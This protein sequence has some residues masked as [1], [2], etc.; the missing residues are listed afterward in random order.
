M[1]VW[2]IIVL[3]I[4]LYL[5][6]FPLVRCFFKRLILMAKIKV[7]CQKKSYRL[8]KKPL[9][10]LGNK[11]FG[12][13]EFQ[14]ETATDI[15][16]IKLFGTPR[17]RRMLMLLPNGKFFIR[18]TIMMIAFTAQAAVFHIDGRMKHMP[19]YR[20]QMASAHTALQKQM[21]KVLLVHPVTMTIHRRLPHGAEL[22]VRDG[23][24]VSGMEVYCLSGFLRMLNEK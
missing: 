8:Y 18:R 20:F 24:L 3:C 10:F 16:A 11:Y 17:R 2:V 21:H 9:W 19:R 23:D 22:I 7:I 15:F 12:Y 5:W 1:K 14:I 4:L 13:S 6:G